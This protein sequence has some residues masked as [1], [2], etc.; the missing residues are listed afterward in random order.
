METGKGR[1][2]NTLGVLLFNSR[3]GSM[4]STMIRVETMDGS[5]IDPS[6]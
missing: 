4:I 2:C 6:R 5:L 3:D 1:Y